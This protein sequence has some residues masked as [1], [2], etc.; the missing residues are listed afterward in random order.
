MTEPRGFPCPE[1]GNTID[2]VTPGAIR[3]CPKL[4]DGG[5]WLSPAG[6]ERERRKMDEAQDFGWPI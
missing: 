6:I 2:I 4:F 5:C 3:F 1:C